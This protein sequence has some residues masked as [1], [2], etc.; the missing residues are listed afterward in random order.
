LQDAGGSVEVHAGVGHA[1][2]V[3]EGG[4]GARLL[5]ALAQEALQHDAGQAALPRRHLLGDGRR[6]QRL[7]AMV[8][9]AVVVA[10]VHH[11]PKRQAGIR[12]Q[13]QR[14]GGVAGLVVRAAAAAAQDHVGI[15]VPGRGHHRGGAVVGDAE[16]RVRGR[17]GAA[18]VHRDLDVPVGAVLEA[19]RHRQAR[20]ELAVDLAFRGPGADRPP[21]HRVRDVLR[22]DRVE[23]LAAHRQAERDDVEQELARGAQAAVDVVAAVHAGVVDQAFPPGDRPRLLEVHP[24]HDEQVLV[25]SATDLG[26]AARVV[27]G[28]RRVVD[29]AGAHDDEQA[30]IG[31]VEHGADF[32]AGPLHGGGGLVGERELV[33]QSR[34]GQQWLVARDPGIPGAGHQARLLPGGPLPER[35]EPAHPLPTGAA[36]PRFLAP[37]GR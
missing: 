37:G 16:E 33:E 27:E 31:G 19:D 6:D 34:R 14:L 30:V 11:E 7:A 18:R 24:H 8:L 3:G 23:P 10:G 5:L 25:V 1:L 28:R 36:L 2:A 35:R 29:R 22:G 13:G 4:R 20:G 15:R 9:A 32:G 26:Q 17:R 12:D 21:G